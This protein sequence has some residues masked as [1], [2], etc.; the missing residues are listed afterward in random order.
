M[1]KVLKNLL[2]RRLLVA[3]LAAVT[4]FGGVYGFAASLNITS[5]KL[6]AGNVAVASCQTAA[7]NSTYT[8]AYDSTLGDY[9]VASVVITGLDKNCASKPIDV[10]LQGASNASL[11]EITGTVPAGGGSLTLTP[12]SSIDAKLVEGVSAAI[13]G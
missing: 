12:S 2:Q 9:K 13:N 8:V 3:T 1:S 11:G 5:N 4:V 7:P 6:A 10:T